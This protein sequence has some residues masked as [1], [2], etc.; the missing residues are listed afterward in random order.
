[1]VQAMVTLDEYE[2]RVLAIVK[3][4]YGLKNKSEAIN[5]VITKFEEDFLEHR[6]KPK[7]KKELKKIAKGKFKAFSSVDELRREIE[8]VSA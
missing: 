3:G 5:L 4:V 2:D 8:N 7:Y 1:M 6:L